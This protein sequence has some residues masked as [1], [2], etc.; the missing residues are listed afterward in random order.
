MLRFFR[1]NAIGKF[2]RINRLRL[3]RLFGF[4]NQRPKV[5]FNAVG[6]PQQ[7]VKC[8]S[9]QFVFHTTDH[10]VRHT[11]AFGDHIHRKTFGHPLLTE[12]ADD[13]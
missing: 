12:Q 5:N 7:G 11:G 6:D 13:R 1:A 9:A 8:G 10:R 2:F 4:F 3:E